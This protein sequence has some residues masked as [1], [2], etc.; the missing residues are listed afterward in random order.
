MET[1]PTTNPATSL[2]CAGPVTCEKMDALKNSNASPL[3]INPKLVLPD[4]VKPYYQDESC[5]IFW[6]D[7]REV[8]PTLP[9]VDLVCTDPPY[10]INAAR[11][12]NTPEYGWVD[13][14]GS[15]WDKVRPNTDTLKMVIKHGNRAIVWGGNY[16]ADV[17]PPSSKFLIWDKGQTDFSLADV[18][19]AWCSWEGAARRI[20][21]PRS[22]ALCDGKVHPTQKSLAVM[23][24]CILQAGDGITS[25]LDPFMG[26]GTT[27][28]AA[29]DLGLKAIG[30]E[31]EEPYCE[32]A[33]KRLAQG[34]LF[35]VEK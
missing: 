13:Y 32:I 5:A 29:K 15:Q 27:L 14:G 26:S 21:I 11:D 9:K 24:W 7:C 12:R 18:E 31:I 3:P 20:L 23:K 25:I 19:M 33:A 6:G 17:L 22:A 16:F 2:F 28:R 30:I 35:G 4:G 1:Q 8:L 34:V 10:G